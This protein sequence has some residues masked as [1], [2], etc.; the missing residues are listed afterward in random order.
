MPH[1]S[2]GGSSSGGSFSGSSSYSGSGSGASSRP[3]TS[4]TYY[5]GY[6]P[7]VRY[8]SGTQEYYYVDKESRKHNAVI[9]CIGSVIA[10]LIIGLIFANFLFAVLSPVEKMQSYQE[11]YTFDGINDEAG[12]LTQDE[13]TRIQE[14]LNRYYST[15][16]IETHVHTITEKIYEEADKDDLETYA[17]YDYVRT[18]D[19][20]DSWLIVVEDMGNGKWQFQGMQGDNTDVWLSEKTTNRFNNTVT[21]SLW[22]EEGYGT[23]LLTGFTE[24]NENALSDIDPMADGG[25]TVFIIAIA[26]FAVLLLVPALI[27]ISCIRT[28]RNTTRKLEKEGYHELSNARMVSVNGESTPLLV[29]CPYCDGTYAFGE[30]SCPHCGAP[31]VTQPTE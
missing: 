30:L 13:K 12:L 14:Q 21:D 8:S 25:Q 28:I 4:R 5:A 9:G 22:R 10:F 1:S 23:A 19:N 31:G 3:T 15:S 17:L 27:L 6:V 11:G 24:L 18:F 7:Y 20:E 16:G 29:T 2:G 26:I